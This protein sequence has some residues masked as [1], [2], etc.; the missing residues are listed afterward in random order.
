V[1]V[2]VPQFEMTDPPEVE[3]QEE[4]Q[5]S[6]SRRM[7]FAAWDKLKGEDDPSADLLAQDTQRRLEYFAREIRN[8]TIEQLAGAI[9]KYYSR[10]TDTAVDTLLKLKE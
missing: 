8:A 2:L 1:E 9:K 3:P 10:T 4:P 6:A 5:Q 7:A